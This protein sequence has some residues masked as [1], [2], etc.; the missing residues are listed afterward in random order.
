MDFMRGKEGFMVVYDKDTGPGKE[1][2]F[3]CRLLPMRFKP[4]LDYYIEFFKRE[5]S[6]Q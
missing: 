2:Q 4:L 3:D 6:I 1:I 5:L